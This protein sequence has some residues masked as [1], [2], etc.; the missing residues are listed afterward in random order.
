MWPARPTWVRSRLQPRASAQSTL[1]STRKAADGEHSAQRQNNEKQGSKVPRAPGQ[2]CTLG[3]LT[4]RQ[5]SSGPS[6]PLA[7]SPLGPRLPQRWGWRCS[8]YRAW[9]EELL[10]QPEPREPGEC[11]SLHEAL[12]GHQAVTPP[13]GPGGLPTVQ[14]HCLSGAVIEGSTS[15]LWGERDHIRV[16][17]RLPFEPI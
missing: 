13:S 5:H 17:E 6:S 11:H 16:L 9:R 3:S 8:V 1:D 7:W 4:F 10:L 15:D 12:F 2:G 14:D